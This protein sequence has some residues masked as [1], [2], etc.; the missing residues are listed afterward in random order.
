MQ[1]NMDDDD[2]SAGSTSHN[3]DTKDEET[4]T[5]LLE[6]EHKLNQAAQ[7]CHETIQMSAPSLLQTSNTPPPT[8]TGR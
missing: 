1:D 2:D 3:D 7:A 4:E 8:Q 6:I 5:Q